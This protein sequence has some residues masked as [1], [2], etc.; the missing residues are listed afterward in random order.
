MRQ[1]QSSE[2]VGWQ[3]VERQWLRKR[4]GRQYGWTFLQVERDIRCCKSGECCMIMGIEHASTNILPQSNDLDQLNLFAV[5]RR[6]LKA[7]PRML[8]MLHACLLASLCRFLTTKT[9]TC[10]L[11][12]HPSELIRQRIFQLNHF[13]R[14]A[15][16]AIVLLLSRPRQRPP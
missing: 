13:R 15:L 7:D 11:L 5:H 10:S 16:P 6:P 2:W 9:G 4:P 12:G 3:C 1:V 14:H 8:D